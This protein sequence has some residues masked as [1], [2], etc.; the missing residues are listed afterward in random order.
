M[1]RLDQ[2]THIIVW[3]GVIGLASL[4]VLA[5]VPEAREQAGMGLAAS[6]GVLA[7]MARQ[8]KDA[9]DA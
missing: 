5:L 2:N 8:A 6:I 7:T 3:T 1:K 9:A 4:I